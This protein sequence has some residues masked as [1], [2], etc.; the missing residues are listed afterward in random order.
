MMQE[1]WVQCEGGTA[2]NLFAPLK[3]VCLYVC[4]RI[5]HSQ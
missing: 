4:A 1:V 3:C 5:K 2:K